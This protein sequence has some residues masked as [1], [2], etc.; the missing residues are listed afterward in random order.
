MVIRSLKD[1]IF[2]RFKVS[3]AEI[4]SNDLWQRCG[5]GIACVSSNRKEAE[6]VIQK[7]IN[8]LETFPNIEIASS[9]FET[10]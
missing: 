5:L 7:V 9:R 3:V 8:Y 6:S 2:H 10:L 4:G 1:K